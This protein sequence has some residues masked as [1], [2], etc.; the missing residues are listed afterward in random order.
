[1]TEITSTN[2]DD[3]AG[4][5]SF[6]LGDLVKMRSSTLSI[7]KYYGF[8]KQDIGV[9]V[10]VKR[11]ILQTKW[12][13]SVYWQAYKSKSGKSTLAHYQYRLKLANRKT[14]KNHAYANK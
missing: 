6:K 2:S 14:H 3:S 9:V 5:P 1:M 12:L 11:N 13:I 10:D 4:S 7:R 8:N